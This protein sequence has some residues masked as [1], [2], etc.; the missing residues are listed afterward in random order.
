MMK[1]K[2]SLD[3]KS[4]SI[5]QPN[6][7]TGQCDSDYFQVGGAVNKVPV[8]CGDNEDQHSRKKF[9]NYYTVEY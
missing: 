1:K 8:I 2:N 5:A 3:F 7:A 6:A 9:S 4:F